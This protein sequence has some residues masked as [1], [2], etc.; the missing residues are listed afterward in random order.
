[1]PVLHV[2]PG[3]ADVEGDSR[4]LALPHMQVHVRL[5]AWDEKVMPEERDERHRRLCRT[6]PNCP[7]CDAQR[8]FLLSDTRPPVWRCRDCR[9]VFEFEPLEEM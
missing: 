3:A 4:D 1:M 2:W 8:V 9:N 6:T 5:R 7:I